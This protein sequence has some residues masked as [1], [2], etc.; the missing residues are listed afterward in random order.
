MAT[1]PPDFKSAHNAVINGETS[2]EQL[3]S[4]FMAEIESRNT[5]TNSFVTTNSGALAAAKQVD[6]FLSKGNKLPLA[7]MILGVK[8]TISV[9]GMGLTCGSRMLSN[10]TALYTAT[11]VARLEAAGAVVIGKTNCDEFAM[12]S[13]NETSWF[14]PAKNPVDESRTPG[15]SSGGSAAA[16]ASRLCNAALGSDTGGSVRQPAAFC[17]L[18]GLKPTYSR[19]SRYGLTAY[20]SSLDCIGP[21]TSDVDTAV[22]MLQF[23][24]GKDPHDAT[25]SSSSRFDSADAREL[26]SGIRIGLPKEYFTEA[27]DPQITNAIHR[28]VASLEKDGIEF[29]EVSLPHTEYGIATYYIL[30]TAEASSNLARYD[31]VRYGY[32]SAA[33]AADLQQLYVRSRSEGFGD[34]VKRRIMLGTYVLSAGYHDRYF[35]KAQKVRTKIHTD[36][37]NVFQK[38]DLLLTPVTPTTAF[39]IASL[40]GKILEMYQ[41]DVFTVPASLAGV[42]AV[43]VPAGL[44]SDGLPVG[45]QLV[46]KHF[47]EGVLMGAARAVQTIAAD[48]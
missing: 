38:V 13:S 23:M 15:G 39:P 7:G 32:R 24:S 2:C 41:S 26:P 34:E 37:D 10:F 20:A 9:R 4:F 46:G 25:S 40:D 33:K 21:M 47:S 36:F 16:V 43:S 31:G 17:G 45:V 29:E 35:A 30:S 22:S 8:D 11:A 12:G 6:T 18:V 27:V 19:V 3:V 1:T 42:P 14:G 44:A 48:S 28:L 5:E